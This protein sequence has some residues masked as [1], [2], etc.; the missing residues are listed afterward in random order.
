MKE[1]RGLKRGQILDTASSGAQFTQPA[2]DLITRCLDDINSF[3]PLRVAEVT[4]LVRRVKEKND[5]DARD[6]L[7]VHNLRLVVSVAKS[8]QFKNRGLGFLDLIQEGTLGLM[9]AIEKYNPSF[10]TKLST[11]AVHWI[12]QSISRAIQDRGATVRLPV[13]VQEFR[14]KVRKVLRLRFQQTGKRSDA[15]EI[16]EVLG[17]SALEV[18]QALIETD[19]NTLSLDEPI[20]DESK[21]KSGTLG[22]TIPDTS[23]F[24][25][26]DLVIARETFDETYTK[27]GILV[28]KLKF[29]KTRDRK[30][31]EMRY[32][33]NQ[34]WLLKKLEE[35]GDL[36]SLSRQRVCQIAADTWKGLASQGFKEGENWLTEQ[37]DLL[38]ILAE[39][40]NVESSETL[41]NSSR[42]PSPQPILIPV[43]LEVQ[44][45]SERL[46]K[47][48]DKPREENRVTKNPGKLVVRPKR[49]IYMTLQEASVAARALGIRNSSDYQKRYKED[50]KLPSCPQYTYQGFMGWESFLEE[51]YVDTR[52]YPISGIKKEEINTRYRARASA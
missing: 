9:R 17:C 50:K 4:E 23:Q 14:R 44:P 19:G 39:I 12:K 36:F 25:A 41:L 42:Q 15:A 26:L 21:G 48:T 51:S 31:F 22:S 11:Y 1:T 20:G 52:I 7:V 47:L 29:L 43:D 27:V 28:S 5:S 49:L 35:V 33:L 10:G 34:R 46:I 38:R 3:P 13:H 45:K 6:K 24:D 32:G 2:K 8:R 30:I 16:A 37:V 18:A 40:L